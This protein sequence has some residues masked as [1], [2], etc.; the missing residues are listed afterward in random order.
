[1]GR[2]TGPVLARAWLAHLSRIDPISLAGKTFLPLSGRPA[3]WFALFAPAAWLGGAV[4]VLVFG[5]AFGRGRD[6]ER[7]G[8]AWLAALLLLGGVIGPDALGAGAGGYLAQR[9]VLLG[10]AAL[11]P[12]LDL[13]SAGFRKRWPAAAAGAMLSVAL[14][15]QS[16]VVWDYALE[17]RDRA[18]A[19]ALPGRRSAGTGG[20]RRS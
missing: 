16:A 17:C 6:P 8:W 7:R 14:A 5:T 15:V 1:M 18:G 2:D 12:A 3:R 10:L 4:A 9:V 11:V 13:E 19:F 20:S